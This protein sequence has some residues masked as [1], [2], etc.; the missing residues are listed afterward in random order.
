M[1]VGRAVLQTQAT[2]ALEKHLDEL[3]PELGKVVNKVTR[4]ALKQKAQ[5]MGTVKEIAEDAESGN[6]TI[7]VEV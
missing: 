4:E 3:Q 1:P 2:E 6:M 7:K 5:Q